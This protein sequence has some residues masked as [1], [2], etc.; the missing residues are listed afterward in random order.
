MAATSTKTWAGT[1]SGMRIGHTNIEGTI[2]TAATMSTIR[3]IMSMIDA[4]AVVVVGTGTG[5]GIGVMV[6][7][8]GQMAAGITRTIGSGIDNCLY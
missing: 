2:T 6:G 7:E 8:I 4:M 1:I 5:T 3:I